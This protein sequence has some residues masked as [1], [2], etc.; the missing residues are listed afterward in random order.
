M[1][2]LN[3]IQIQNI[4][5]G[6]VLIYS[7]QKAYLIVESDIEFSAI[8]IFNNGNEELGYINYYD[9]NLKDLIYRI[10]KDYGI[11]KKIVNIK[12]VK[13]KV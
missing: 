4:N 1:I 11:P 12:D 2:C 7:E 13:V 5:T 3:K 6:D 8:Q 9:T 10:T